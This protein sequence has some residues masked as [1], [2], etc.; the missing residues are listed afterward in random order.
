MAS[1]SVWAYTIIRTNAAKYNHISPADPQM[2]K[3]MDSDPQ[4]HHAPGGREKKLLIPSQLV[5]PFLPF[6]LKQQFDH[7]VYVAY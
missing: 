1:S 3:S 4:N 2:V 5:V 6:G 7:F